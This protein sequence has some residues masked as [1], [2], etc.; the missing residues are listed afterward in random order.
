MGLFDLFAGPDMN[1]GVQ[2]WKASKGAV[3]LDVRSAD[4][5]GQ[6]HIPGQ[7]QRSARSYQPGA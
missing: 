4:E 2:E 3:L 6:G 5:Y 1:V 7:R